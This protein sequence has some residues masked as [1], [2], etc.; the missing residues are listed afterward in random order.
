MNEWISVKDRMPE[1]NEKN[2]KKRYVLVFIPER[3]GCSQNGIY[4]ATLKHVSEDD[5]TGN[6]WGIRTE[7]SDWEIWSWSYFENPIVTHWMPLPEPPK[8]EE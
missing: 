4:I 6:F 3:E 2:D 7:E 8:G 1:E 5:G